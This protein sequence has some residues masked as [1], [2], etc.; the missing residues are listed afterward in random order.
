MNAFQGRGAPELDLLETTKCSHFYTDLAL[1]YGVAKT[2]S[3][4]LQSTQ[5]GPRLD[6]VYDTIAEPLLGVWGVVTAI[7]TWVYETQLEAFGQVIGFVRHGY[8]VFLMDRWVGAQTLRFYVHAGNTAAQL[9]EL[10]LSP[11][12]FV[13][14]EYGVMVRRA[15]FLSLAA[16]IGVLVAAESVDQVDALERTFDEQHPT[17]YAP[18]YLGGAEIPLPVWLLEFD[19][20]AMATMT[21]L[22]TTTCDPHTATTPRSLTHLLSPSV[23]TLLCADGVWACP[24]AAS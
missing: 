5:I 13:F 16:V 24:F 12:V 23:C 14:L 8:I 20:V 4:L 2:D 9:V 6:D 21:A 1:S 19:E 11:L 3:C 15:P 22:V 10:L 17:T 18:A 7:T